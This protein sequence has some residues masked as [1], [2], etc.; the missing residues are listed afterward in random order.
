M[1]KRNRSSGRSCFPTKPLDKKDKPC[2]RRPPPPG[3]KHGEVSRL[4]MSHRANPQENQKG[5]HSVQRLCLGG[6][7][8]PVLPPLLRSCFW[9]WISPIL[10]RENRRII[11]L[12]IQ[13]CLL[14]LLQ[15]YPF[16]FAESPLP[17]SLLILYPLEVS[18]IF[19]SR[20]IFILPSIF[21]TLMPPLTF[22]SLF[23][24]LFRS[25][26]SLIFHNSHVLCCPSSH[27]KVPVSCICVILQQSP[28]LIPVQWQNS[29]W[30]QW[31]WGSWSIYGFVQYT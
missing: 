2:S 8:A 20:P 14:L 6:G 29:Y 31:K 22:S 23:C 9:H 18:L 27:L 19:T 25:P 7:L 26:L 24:N 17:H 30:F 16:H 28:A 11:H 12:F 4:V 5:S 15:N 10:L 21:A 1:Q 13:R 3:R